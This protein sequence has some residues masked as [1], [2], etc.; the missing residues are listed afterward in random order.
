MKLTQHQQ[1]IFTYLKGVESA[2]LDEITKAVPINYYCNAKF[3]IGNILSRMV[4][5]KIIVRVKKGT[6]ALKR[7]RQP[8]TSQI[9]L[10][11]NI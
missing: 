5:A 1:T 4:K 9:G 3:H 7:I 6:Y 10:F 8:E 11:E 2:T